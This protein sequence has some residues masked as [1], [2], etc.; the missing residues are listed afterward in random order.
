MVLKKHF[1]VK[2]EQ[3]QR[4]SGSTKRNYCAVCDGW[5]CVGG[6]EF[7]TKEKLCKDCY[8]N[9]DR[10]TLLC[11]FPYKLLLLSTNTRIA[12]QSSVSTQ[13]FAEKKSTKVDI[14]FCC[15]CLL[16]LSQEVLSC[17]EW[18]KWTSQV[19]KF[20]GEEIKGSIWDRNGKLSFTFSRMSCSWNHAVCSLSDSSKSFA[21]FQ[22]LY[23]IPEIQSWIR[24][25]FFSLGECKSTCHKHFAQ[26]SVYGNSGPFHDKLVKS[27][28]S[29]FLNPFIIWTHQATSPDTFLDQYLA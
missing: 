3:G 18:E 2:H 14:S 7:V 1:Q 27:D 5:K 25:I 29:Y 24:L 20:C 28:C 16:H 23:W 15:I 22:A 4:S 12:P 9:G 19:E 13:W 6:A 10:E 21:M 11:K 8:L 17:L 26:S